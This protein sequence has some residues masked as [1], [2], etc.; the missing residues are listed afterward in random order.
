M[1]KEI[2]MING[3]LFPHMMRFAIPI[4]LSGVLQTLYNAADSLIVGRYGSSNA[5]GAVGSVGPI[6]N[7][8]LNLFL[9]FATGT[10]VI[11]ARYW[12]A[13]DKQLVKRASDT[14][15]ILALISGFLSG[16]LGIIISNPIANWVKI[17]SEI[18][19][20]SVLYM[21]I[22]FI[23]LPFTSLYNFAASAMR[24][25]GNTKGP[26]VCLIVSGAINVIFNIIFV[27]F[28]A[29]GVAGVAIATVISQI[30]SAV[31]M[32]YM[33]KNSVIGISI[34]NIMFDRKIFK[35]TIKIGIPAGIQ[36]MVFSLSNTITI[37]AVNS[38]GAAA[39]AA[40]TVAGQV[41]GII[42]VALNSITQ[43]V[44]TFTS[45]NIG[46][47]KPERLNPIIF[48]GFAITIIGGLI[49]SLISYIFKDFIINLFAP[50][51]SDVWKYAIIKFQYV[52]LPYCAVGLMEIPAGMLRGM[53]AT[54]T[55]MVMSILGV[56]GFRILWQ[57]CIFPMHHTLDF[58]YISYPISWIG[59]GLVYLIAYIV[60][61]KR[62]NR[63]I[64]S[65]KESFSI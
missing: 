51:E 24:A 33:L 64:A 47:K 25:I 26:M 5:L 60:L 46:A 2:D 57:L 35:Y 7:I 11:V 56:C 12:G 34:K 19:D 50:G 41:E 14:A 42:Y 43:T 45:Q 39:A 4:V 13:G 29:M 48:R 18:I 6:I 10:N 58:L 17:D 31:M 22:Y 8:I 36:G 55:A 16:I 28:C 15:I 27:K 30:I 37:S 53:N 38:F 23:G 1:K 61:K 40:N 3:R 49:L 63:S 9:G 65:G 21:R 62:L 54:F 20:M 59:T 32:I 44:T 52:I